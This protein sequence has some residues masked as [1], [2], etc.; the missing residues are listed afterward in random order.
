MC[1]GHPD[2]FYYQNTEFLIVTYSSGQ[3]FNPLYSD[4]TSD[5]VS[6]ETLSDFL[7]IYTI[8]SNRL[9]LAD[10]GL[11]LSERTHPY[12]SKPGPMIRGIFPEFDDMQSFYFNNLYCGLKYPLHYTGNL[13]L[14]ARYSGNYAGNALWE[15][16]RV[17]ELTF[18][19]GI[20]ALEIDRS[21]QME[22]IRELVL[23]Y[24]KQDDEDKQCLRQKIMEM[25]AATFEPTFEHIQT[26]FN[27]L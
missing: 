24:K 12:K 7:A 2:L 16:K 3:L 6:T 5:H 23:E 11:E 1:C 4:L 26:L 9:I 17:I 20:F 19:H 8:R 25:V 14:A 18:E 21:Q 22:A 13:L 10:L 15:Y 27:P